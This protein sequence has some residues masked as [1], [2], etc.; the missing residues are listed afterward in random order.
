MV[1]AHPGARGDHRAP[2]RRLGSVLAPGRPE[3]RW[4]SGVRLG[5]RRR[6][7]RRG[8][9][10]RALRPAVVHGDAGLGAHPACAAVRRPANLATERP[11]HRPV[12]AGARSALRGTRL[13]LSG[14]E[15]AQPLEV[16]DAAV[17]EG[18][19]GRAED[20]PRD[21]QRLLR[22]REARPAACPR[23]DGGYRAVRR[24]RPRQADDAGDLLAQRAQEARPVRRART[25][26]LFRRR[27]DAPCPQRGGR[28]DSGHGQAEA[29][30]GARAQ[31]GADVGHGGLLR[32]QAP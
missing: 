6:R 7:R 2:G 1:R 24:L 5:S 27:P 25:S 29:P 20:L 22:R 23:G 3:R 16:P 28:L 30:S 4:G 32:L 17:V 21:P 9:R 31:E 8:A 10:A 19:A 11:P 13:E 14:V 15:R 18:Q 12:R 26:P